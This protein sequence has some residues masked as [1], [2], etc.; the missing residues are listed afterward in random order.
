ML[1]A[2]ALTNICGFLGPN[3]SKGINA[4]KKETNVDRKRKV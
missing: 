2:L 3:Y 4:R 1:V